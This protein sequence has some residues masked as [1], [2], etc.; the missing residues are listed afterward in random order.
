MDISKSTYSSSI[1]FQEHL[2]LGIYLVRDLTYGVS[3]S[4]EI[5][6]KWWSGAFIFSFSF[7]SILNTENSQKKKTIL[8]FASAFVCWSSAKLFFLKHK[9]SHD[10]G[11]RA[12]VTMEISKSIC[13][14]S[15]EF[16]QGLSLDQAKLVILELEQGEIKG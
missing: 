1:E 11:T 4:R 14:S 13:S 16:Q 10:F 5:H 9:K 6:Y 2:V 8:Y 15:I 7:N 3:L 12:K